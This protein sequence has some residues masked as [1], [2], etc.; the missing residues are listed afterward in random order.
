MK[1]IG[2]E[3]AI[4]TNDIEVDWLLRGI[5]A[6]IREFNAQD[7][8]DPFVDCDDLPPTLKCLKNDLEDILNE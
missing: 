5:K 4:S 2:I 3:Y 6:L 7:G 8:G 1:K